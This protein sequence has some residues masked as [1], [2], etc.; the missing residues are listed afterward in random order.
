MWPLLD[1]L[2]VAPDNHRPGIV[3]PSGFGGIFDTRLARPHIHNVVHNVVRNAVRKAVQ[4]ALHTVCDDV[5]TKMA[6]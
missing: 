1:S 5:C 2:A 4:I 6:M 3:E